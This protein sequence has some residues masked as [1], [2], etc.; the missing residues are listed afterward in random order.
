M[1]SEHPPVRLAALGQCPVERWGARRALLRCWMTGGRRGRRDEKTSSSSTACGW[2]VGVR[3]VPVP[4]RGDHVG[5]ALVSGFGLSYRDLEELLYE[6][7]VEVDHVTL[8]RWVQRF[9]PI[10]IEAIY[11]FQCAVG[12]VALWCVGQSSCLFLTTA[13]AFCVNLDVDGRSWAGVGVWQPRQ[14]SHAKARRRRMRSRAGRSS[15]R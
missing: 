3:R 2:V 9:T 14:D 10:L 12:S 5:G 11:P 13:N 6:R 15:S 7:G 1:A 8:F 4:T